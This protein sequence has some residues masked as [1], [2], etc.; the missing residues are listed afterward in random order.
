MTM[1]IILTF[2]S[3]FQYGYNLW[4]VNHPAAVIQD[5]YNITLRMKKKE[6]QQVNGLSFLT[7]GVIANLL[8][9]ISAIFMG[10]STIV[11]TYE[12]AI[13]SRLLSGV[14]SGIFSCAVPLYL[15]EIAPRNLRGGIITMAMIAIGVGV[16]FSQILGLHEFLEWAILLSLT[17]ILAVFQLLILPN[18]PESP[19]FLLIQRKNEE[20]ARKVLRVLRDKEDVEEEIEELH[21][22]DIDNWGGC[23]SDHH[24]FLLLFL[25]FLF[26]VPPLPLFFFFS[27]SSSSFPSL[28]FSS[29]LPLFPLFSPFSS[30]FSSSS[31]SSFPS[32][33]SPFSSSL[34]P[35]P[36]SPHLS[37]LLPSPSSPC[38]PPF[39]PPLP[40]PPLP[41]SSPSSP[42]F[43]L[44][45]FFLFLL[46]LTH[47]LP[48]PSSPCFP[49]F[50]PPLP[51]PP[52][53]PSPPSS[54]PFLLL[55]FFLFL[56]PLTHLLLLS[57]PPLPF[58]FPLFFLF[59]SF[60]FPS[61]TSPALLLLFLL[62][63]S[64]SSSS[65][66]SSSSSSSLSP[67][68]PPPLPPL[69]SPPPPLPPAGPIP[70]IIIAELFLQSSRSTGIVLGGFVHWFLRIITGIMVF[71]VEVSEFELV[72]EPLLI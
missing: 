63:P 50:L 55:L 68:P 43:L 49:P 9:F 7:P 66:F 33:L 54:P 20:K 72:A 41:P 6:P 46:P 35:L 21:Q 8:A 32:L 24:L 38:F 39:L 57:P 59:S 52:L 26:P 3:S 29:P 34:P 37:H 2:G 12:Y 62:L 56:L 17:G 71:E 42:P 15:A 5:Y 1:T 31:S 28:I 47:L 48:S 22:E 64:S 65:P 18:F 36:P 25:L 61:P 14:C 27:S 19:R 23:L 70:N 44:L 67:P 53:P 13:F 51:L 60:S 10:F 69:P 16:L 45:L 4:V 30:S 58:V 40:L 11:H